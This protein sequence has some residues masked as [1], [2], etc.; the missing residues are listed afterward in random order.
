LLKV[1]LDPKTHD[2][3]LRTLRSQVTNTC[4]LYLS[5]TAD[6][7][8]LRRLLGIRYVHYTESSVNEIKCWW[9][10]WYKNYAL[11]PTC[12]GNSWFRRL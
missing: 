11:Q 12:V 4:S 9:W 8:C 3:Y 1:A 10:R 6:R 7:K 5:E 2:E